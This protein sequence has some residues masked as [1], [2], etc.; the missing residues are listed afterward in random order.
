[1]RCVIRAK[2]RRAGRLPQARRHA[3][4]RGQRHRPGH[5]ADRREAILRNSSA[6]ATIAADHGG[7][8]LG[9]SIVRR[10]A[11]ALEHPIDLWSRSRLWLDLLD[12]S[13]RSTGR[14]RSRR[15]DA[16]LACGRVYGL[17]GADVL[18]VENEPAVAQAMSALLQ[19]WGCGVTWRLRAADAMEA[20]RERPRRPI[21]LSPISISTMVRTASKS[22][23]KFN[24][25]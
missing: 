19:R 15:S 6:A 12:Q 23:V 1:M 14:S 17:D 25:N 7:F 2:R 3:A 18:L 16:T 4:H 8:G 21:S 9:L 20:L 10:L 24:A 5:R 22:Y 11:A 13:C